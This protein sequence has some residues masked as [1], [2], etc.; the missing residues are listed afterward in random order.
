MGD[1]RGEHRSRKVVK[2]NRWGVVSKGR[3]LTRRTLSEPRPASVM[4][5]R[6]SA[7]PPRSQE[8]EESGV[9]RQF[10]ER[11]IEYRRHREAIHYVEGEKMTN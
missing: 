11:T 8:R 6:R 5:R 1:V 9:R 3:L 7:R 2:Y 4:R 10:K